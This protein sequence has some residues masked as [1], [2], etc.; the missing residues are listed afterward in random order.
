M[1]AGDAAGDAAAA[2]G[3]LS[4]LSQ[5]GAP[6]VTFAAMRSVSESLSPFSGQEQGMGRLPST[7]GYE[8]PSLPL[9]PCMPAMGRMHSLTLPGHSRSL[10][11]GSSYGSLSRNPSLTRTPSE[12]S[13]D[14]LSR[15]PSIGRISTADMNAFG[16]Q[17]PILSRNLSST[18]DGMGS[19]SMSRTSSLESVSPSSVAV[20]TAAG[21]RMLPASLALSQQLRTGQPT[22]AT[23]RSPADILASFL[24][25]KSYNQVYV[26]CCPLPRIVR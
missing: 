9:P 4:A 3:S 24:S 6:A 14:S 21:Q 10:S 18:S 22:G 20:Q 8:V 26:P 7:D 12:S 23:P 5:S 16:D 25:P 13:V 1:S 17:D 19:L 2:A 15:I 11:N